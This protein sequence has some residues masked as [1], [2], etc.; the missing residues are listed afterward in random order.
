MYEKFSDLQP[1]QRPTKISG[2]SQS[3]NNFE[4]IWRF[5]MDIVEIRDE[6]IRSASNLCR[7]VAR[8]AATNPIEEPP[9]EEA[10]KRQPRGNR[11]K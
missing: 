3:Y 4:D 9:K 2:H 1:P 6:S 8:S 11:N 5:K 10:K 7:M